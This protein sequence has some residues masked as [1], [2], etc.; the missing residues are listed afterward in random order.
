MAHVKMIHMME[1]ALTC[2]DY[3]IADSD[4]RISVLEQIWLAWNFQTDQHHYFVFWIQPEALQERASA[5][6]SDAFYGLWFQQFSKRQS[7]GFLGLTILGFALFCKT[8]DEPVR[9]VAVQ[10][11]PLLLFCCLP[12]VEVL[13]L[14]SVLLP[15]DF[16]STNS[17]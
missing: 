4:H 13:G 2:E 12:S 6:P 7:S 16:G 1:M 9:P 5:F 10:P 17:A 15:G 8:P 3:S 11:E 14:V